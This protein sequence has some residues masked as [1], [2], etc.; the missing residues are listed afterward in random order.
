LDSSEFVYQP[1][2]WDLGTVEERIHHLRRLVLLHSILYYR[3]DNPIISDGQFDSWARELAKKQK[4]NPEASE[5]VHYH[6][7]AFRDFEG[8]TGFHLPLEDE[9]TLARATKILEGQ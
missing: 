6:K 9:R 7:E 4:D 1:E 8:E 3:F 2:H 5:R